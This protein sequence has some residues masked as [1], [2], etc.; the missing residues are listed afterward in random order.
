V[1]QFVAGGPSLVAAVTGG[2]TMIILMFLSKKIPLLKELA[3]GI[4]MLVGMIATVP[5]L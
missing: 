4:S 2:I 1:P 5:F 3:L